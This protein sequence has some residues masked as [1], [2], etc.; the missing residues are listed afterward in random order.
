M[1]LT[2][3]NQLAIAFKKLAGKSHTN[4]SFG[5]GNEAIPSLLQVG[6]TSIFGQAI[7]TTGIPS[8][9][10]SVDANNIV[11]KVR[12]ELSAIPLS[13]Y[14]D[15]NP[16]GLTSATI[17]ASGDGAPTQGTFTNGYH[18]YA[19]KITGSY[20]LNSSNP[21]K[22]S[23]PFTDGYFL[24]GSAGKLQLVPDSFNSGYSAIVLNGPTEG[25]N[26][27]APGDE[28]DYYVDYSTGMLFVQDYN[29][30]NLPLYVDGYLYIGDYLNT[31]ITNNSSSFS[32]SLSSFSSSV[33][34]TINNLSS[35]LGTISSSINTSITN[36]SSSFSSSLASVSSS[37]STTD[38][39]NSSSFSTTITNLSSS[40]S[41][42]I[43]SVSSSV[44]HLSQNSIQS[45]STSL[46]ALPNSITSVVN[47]VTTQQNIQTGVE[48][49]VPVTG[50]IFSGSFIGN[51]AQLINVSASYIGNSITN[52]AQ[53]RILTSNG[54]GTL[55]GESGLTYSGSVF[56]VTGK[57][58]ITSDL[59]VGGN[60]IV[61]GT[62][63]FINS[64]NLYVKDRFVQFASGSTT[65]VDSGIVSEYNAA[66]SGSAFF[67]S[68]VSTG[69]YGRWSVA[70]D[71][72]GTATS[73]TPSEY[74]VTA[75]LSPSSV[76]SSAPTW[77][78]ST[79]GQ[80][81][82]WIKEDTGDIY[83]YS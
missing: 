76:P 82:I 39:N 43:A 62:A 40:L 2:Q 21:K 35:S 71:V 78:G 17:N 31:T 64:D 34:T 29:S 49:F 72:V 3:L 20:N 46:T 50:S 37:L 47:T 70:Y 1:A 79:N 59:T 75:N 63:T 55:N 36:L 52:D 60:I 41:A 18:A 66:G 7:P 14:Q 13:Q 12:F 45:G 57:Q 58:T 15:S 25:T 81:N 26:T 11:E 38:V 61:N 4:S 8:S 9:I 48:F 69:T 22:G 73:V 27:I 16:G 5:I 56:Q 6:S 68:S 10:F 24:S 74:V 28:I 33:T 65:L 51:G 53:Y 30:S 77:G 42:S 32:S 19:L 80:G 83:I 67:L 23:I 54:N 44:V